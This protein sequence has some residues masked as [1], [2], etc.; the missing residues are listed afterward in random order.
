M[1]TIAF[2]FVL[3]LLYLAP[4]IQR[5]LGRVGALVLTK[6]LYVFIA[7]KAVAFVISGI[8]WFRLCRVGPFP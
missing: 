5:A 1:L 3:P 8:F 7:A 4:L 6:I 2:S